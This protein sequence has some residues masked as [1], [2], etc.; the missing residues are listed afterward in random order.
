MIFIDWI[1]TSD[2]KNFNNAFFSNLKKNNKHQLFVFSKSLKTKKINCHVKKNKNS[3]F[4]RFLE[5]IKICFFFR[6]NS[7]FFLTYDPL[8]LPLTKFFVKKKI[9]TYEH[10]T[11]PEK[12]ID[13]HSIFQYFFFRTFVRLAQF[14]G[15]KKILIKINQNVNYLGSPLNNLKLKK[16]N[17][18]KKSINKYF[19]SPSY[20]EDL[21]LLKKKLNLLKDYKIFLKSIL[22]NDRLTVKNLPSNFYLVK[23]IKIDNFEKN[24]LGIIVSIN[25][26]I[27]GSGWFNEAISRGIPI[28]ILSKK[29]RKLFIETFPN[30]PH[31]FLDN[32]KNINHLKKE[33]KRIK[34]FKS[35]KYLIKHNK[36]FREL[37]ESQIH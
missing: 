10:N 31:I 6:N 13:K 9:F 33:I 29:T 34:K 7:I 35:K 22:F 8:F 23:R 1:S 15:Q 4:V 27:R 30:Y 21:S 20:R 24:I 25:S 5:I 3:R 16:K 2:H 17:F 32:I 18:Y 12:I 14:K 26:S 37:L 36:K 11:V 19:I 28:I